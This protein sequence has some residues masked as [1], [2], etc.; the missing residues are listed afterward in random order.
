MSH[1]VI[2][3]TDPGVDDA[4]A[5][6]LC[7]AHP[8]I[9]LLALTTVFGNV[10]VDQSTRNAQ[11]VLDV[12][13]ATNVS[14]AKGLGKPI[15]QPPLP[16]SESVHGGDGL[17]NC[18]D[19]SRVLNKQAKHAEL[20]SLPA[21]EYII[22]QAKQHP[23][24][25][26]L[27]AIGPLSNVA[28]ALE[29]EPKLP[30]LLR[31]LIIMGGALDEPGNVSPVAEANF[32]NDPHAADQ[33]LA[34]DWPACVIGLDVT[35][36]IMVT[37]THLGTLRDKAGETGKLLWDSS[38]FYVDFYVGKGAAKDSE[39]PACA[40]HDAAA[41]LY[42]L[43]PK[44]FDLITGRTRVVD[45]GIA[46]GQLTCDRKGYEYALPHWKGGTSNTA[47]ATAVNDESVRQEFLNCLINH[48]VT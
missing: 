31:S 1:Q 35:H 33:V 22:A 4:M 26:T 39:E 8:E 41:V 38:R 32:L 27:I 14:V 20:D 9:E 3:D 46:V 15:V 7:I 42:L 17:G 48:H 2:L 45:S 21:A 11:Y 40:M 30:E 28:K 10:S 37:D 34:V 29:I 16:H 13:G 12:F 44:A 18:W 43:M 5:I 36:R 47:I 6:A 23:G 25:I 24:Q 19:A